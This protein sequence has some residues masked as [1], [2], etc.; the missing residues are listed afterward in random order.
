MTARVLILLLV[1]AGGCGETPPKLPRL[2]DDAV[3]LSFGDSLTHGSGAQAARSYPAVLATLIGR[4]VIRSGVPGE[5]SRQGRERLGAELARHRPA[6]LILCHGA[7]DMLRRR[8][9]ATMEENLIAMIGQV[10]AQGAAVLL[11]G[12]PRPALLGL[13]SAEVYQRVAAATGVPLLADVMPRVLSD[14]RMKSDAFHPNAEGY[15]AVAT[16]VA[17]FLREAGAVP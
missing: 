11:L 6:L 7:N 16:A 5:L 3:V 14:N 15:A 4:T 9:L 10:R 13:E 8:P 17:E 12:V 2:A 1:L